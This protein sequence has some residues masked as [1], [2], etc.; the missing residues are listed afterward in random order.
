M[1]GNIE[2]FLKKKVTYLRMT[3]LILKLVNYSTNQC[4]E[5]RKD[6]EQI[7]IDTVKFIKSTDWALFT[8]LQKENA[9]FT[10]LK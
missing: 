8:Q 1:L 6:L 5:F 10:A 4:Y 2:N 9:L 7:N 3:S